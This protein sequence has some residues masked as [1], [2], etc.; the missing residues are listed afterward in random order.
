MKIV[1]KI[2]IAASAVIAL[3]VNTASALTL[4]SVSK[5]YKT[6]RE[7]YNEGTDQETINAALERLRDSC[8]SYCNSLTCDVPKIAKECAA[9]CPYDTIK[10]CL[11]QQSVMN[12]P[13]RTKMVSSLNIAQIDDND[14]PVSKIPVSTKGAKAT[15]TVT[16]GQ[17]QDDGS[18]LC[19]FKGTSTPQQTTAPAQQQPTSQPKPVAQQPVQQQSVQQAPAKS[20]CQI[21]A[22][23]NGL[24]SEQ[25]ARDYGLCA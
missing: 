4:S 3:G 5:S 1:T 13:A 15:T 9:R 24:S 16:K 22:E 6:Y 12:D 25:E 18:C 19:E 17:K 10:N 8:N 14:V 20:A 21:A 11:K 23:Q 2:L 7:A